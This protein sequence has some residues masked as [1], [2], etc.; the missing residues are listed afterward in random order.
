MSLENV[1]NQ[2]NDAFIGQIESLPDEVSEPTLSTLDYIKKRAK[3]NDYEATQ[4]QFL[5]S[6]Q[7]AQKQGYKY[8]CRYIAGLSTPEED[9]AD[10]YKSIR[11]SWDRFLDKF[12][13]MSVEERAEAF[14]LSINI[15]E[16]EK[17]LNDSSPSKLEYITEK[18]E[19][20]VEEIED[21]ANE[22]SSKS[23]VYLTTHLKY[24]KKTANELESLVQDY[25]K[26]TM[27]AAH[28]YDIKNSYIDK[29][30]DDEEIGW[31][32]IDVIY[33]ADSYSNAINVVNML[34]SIGKP[35]QVLKGAETIVGNNNDP[36][37]KGDLLQFKITKE[38]NSGENPIYRYAQVHHLDTKKE[39]NDTPNS[40]PLSG[41]V[42]EVRL[43]P[44]EVE[45]WNAK[46]KT[47]TKGN[48]NSLRFRECEFHSIGV[49][50]WFNKGD[51]VD[52][53]NNVLDPNEWTNN[54]NGTATNIKTGDI[55]KIE[56]ID[57]DSWYTTS[58]FD[59]PD[60]IIH[61]DKQSDVV[62]EKK[63]DNGNVIESKL[64]P[65][66]LYSVY[67][68]GCTGI[69]AKLEQ[70]HKPDVLLLVTSCMSVVTGCLAI[71]V[72]AAALIYAIKAITMA[73]AADPVKFLG[74]TISAAMA[75]PLL[76]GAIASIL[77]GI[78][79]TAAGSVGIQDYNTDKSDM[80]EIHKNIQRH[81]TKPFDA[82]PIGENGWVTING[83][84]YY[85]ISTEAG[86]LSVASNMLK[87]K[88]GEDVI[89]FFELAYTGHTSRYGKGIP[90]PRRRTN[91][92]Y[93]D[94][95]MDITEL[96]IPMPNIAKDEGDINHD[97]EG[98]MINLLIENL[99]DKK[100]K[101]I[102]D[103][104]KLSPNDELVVGYGYQGIM[105]EIGLDTGSK[106]DAIN[107]ANMFLRVQIKKNSK[108]NP[109]NAEFAAIA[110]QPKYT[111]T[112]DVKDKHLTRETHK[113]T[114]LMK[115][116]DNSQWYQ[117]GKK[118]WEETPH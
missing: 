73:T 115:K 7:S 25:S 94:R 26:S 69:E 66:V 72:G 80:N 56:V 6:E 12:S 16:I 87:N 29:G 48:I 58:V 11:K 75:A 30:S 111:P 52:E 14:T 40:K 64:D 117:W 17:T 70:V 51:M 28:A 21:M 100:L 71:I 27:T 74:F 78:G 102:S 65:A 99:N 90:S 50:I 104:N 93:I 76:V 98:K 36:L 68:S 35:A 83:K 101:I 60:H 96:D 92:A 77:S 22:L 13:K 1:K 37:K 108:D 110:F 3:C 62:I 55:I 105:K 82:F 89:I 97:H 5:M 63:D 49:Y 31:E 15:E 118:D 84:K 24:T 9:N 41:T 46:G 103:P 95:S 112:P 91:L 67:N 113:I 32:S 43:K 88:K 57:L 47:I 34:K 114:V 81:N 54:N 116:Q 85:M 109:E 10:Y 61:F 44:L 39:K 19:S 4:I 53:K 33:S 18:T 45:A 23:T 42:R 106:N 8:Y 2:L 20:Q 107:Q 38:K 59:Y 86:T 79:L